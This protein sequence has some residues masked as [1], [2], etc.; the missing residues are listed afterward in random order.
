MT[1]RARTPYAL[2]RR[3]LALGGGCRLRDCGIAVG[4]GGSTAAGSRLAFW[5]GFPV[6]AVTLIL[7]HDLTGGAGGA[8]R[9][10]R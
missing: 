6:G 4:G 5:S 8:G 1:E 7:A 2:V 9:G 10:R 3:G